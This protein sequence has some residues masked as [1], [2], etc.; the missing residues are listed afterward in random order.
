M[1]ILIGGN[2]IRKCKSNYDI[3]LNLLIQLASLQTSFRE[4][5]E[6]MRVTN[7]R[8][9]ALDNVVIP[10]LENTMMYIKSELDERER[11]D[12]FRLKK[13]VAK[14][15][16]E[17]KIIDALKKLEDQNEYNNDETNYDND[18]IIDDEKINDDDLVIDDL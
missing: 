7:R 17:Q 8:V 2:Q 1:L 18:V 10:K 4:L 14:K 11:E 5:D 6:A 3:A 13:V 12:L 9:N 16:E 15:K